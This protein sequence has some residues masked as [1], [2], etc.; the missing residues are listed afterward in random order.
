MDQEKVQSDVNVIGAGPVGAVFAL[1]AARF[2]VKV[3][4]LDAR[5][6]PSR[7]AR[8]LALSHGSRAILERVGVWETCAP[9]SA[10]IHRIHTSQQGAF[11][12]AVIDRTDAGVPALGYVIAYADLQDAL[13]AALQ[14]AGI[15]VEFGARVASI[16][17]DAAGVRIA[18]ESG[19]T[20]KGAAA[21]LADGGANLSKLPR[22][23]SIEK[24]YEQS[25]LLA[26]IACDLPHRHVAYERFTPEG[27]CALLPALEV[28]AYSMVW[29]AAHARIDT[30]MALDDAAFL[31]AFQAHFGHRAGRFVSMGARNRFPLKLRTVAPRASGRIAVIGNAAQALHPVA[32][33]GFNLGL[34]DALA[35]AESLSQPGIETLAALNAYAATRHS[36]VERSI[37]FT[38]L[39]VGLF[40]SAHAPTQAVRGLGLAAL[41]ALPLA[42]RVLAA[43][44]SFGA[45]K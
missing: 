26:H 10:E 7:E 15:G 45:P 17:D 28:N 37:G 23:A 35:L 12:R 38:D 44:M 31:A 19:G 29:V 25:A 32:G 24:D 43:R 11:G 3:S 40:G 8:T 27:P 5:T 2:G 4:L 16:S 1:L 20:M 36:D 13:D 41:D 14:R 42:R 9:Q 22:F 34:R 33:Q 39:L 6:G 18:L 21:V 30:R